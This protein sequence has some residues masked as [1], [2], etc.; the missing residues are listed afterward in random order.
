[1]AQPVPEPS[2]LRARPGSRTETPLCQLA[3]GVSAL[4]GWRRYGLSFLLG[5]CATAT[6]PPVDLAPL[7]LVAFPGLLWLDE[8][9]AGPWASFRLGY[10]FGLG[11]FVSGL[12]WIAGALLVDIA[13]F[14]WLMPFAVLGLPAAFALYSGL[15]LCATKLATNRLRLP[16]P[17][18]VFAFAVAWT[19][20]EW[21]RGHAFTGLPWNL[22][23]Y[24]WSGGFPGATAVLQSVAWIG[25]YGL[26][27]LTVLAA[28]L[29][30]LLGSPS[31]A[32]MS[33]VRRLAPALGAGLLIVVPGVFGA[34]RLQTTPTVDRGI[35]L[36]IV[37]PS[38]PQTMKWDPRAAE[39]N[40]RLLLDLSASPASQPIA[41]VIWPEAA[42][43]FLLERN[44]PLRRQIGSIAS[45]RGYVITG[46]VRANP[47][48]DPVKQVWNSLEVV[49]KDGEI[50]ARYDK[51]HLVPFGE[52]VPLRRTLPLKKITPGSLDFSAGPGPRTLAL[53]GLPRFAAAICYE[54]IFP[55]A[56]VDEEDRPQW[57][58]NVTND[59]WYGRTS[60]PY[61]HFA[62]ART[63]A[64][65]EGLP[66]IRVANN[67][68]SGVVDPVGR[69][70][71]RIALDTVGYADLPLPAA[72]GPTPYAR[73][74]D[75]L[76]LG[77]L[78]LGA[79]P[80]VFRLR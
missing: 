64:V 48:P 29:P 41:A 3:Q 34:I 50:V 13:S 53:K 69:V 25:I 76:L 65:E 24:A 2:V 56:V 28:S 75:W 46:A 35:W 51:A 39:R 12:Y 23:G 60:G 57:I 45:E 49:N 11:F 63:R 10:T 72:L 30:A 47:P 15:A 32:P 68:V 61:Q 17:A 9:S 74:G 40:F 21:V 52:Y 6:L 44:P 59:A 7:L 18:R 70:L 14:W 62:I 22:I 1:M 4:S 16:G 77:L 19:I 71:G 36:R 54:V 8:G 66:L 31:L 55:G 80:A 20:A 5:V 58:L 67:G 37:Q 26:S 73:A 42:I 38:T 27:F 78:L 79:L 43:P 33:L